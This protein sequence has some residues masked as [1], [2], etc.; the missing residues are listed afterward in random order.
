MENDAQLEQ[1]RFTFN[2][3]H[4]YLRELSFSVE[5]VPISFMSVDQVSFRLRLTPAMLNSNYIALAK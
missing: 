4:R 5:G 1:G 2:N 3:I